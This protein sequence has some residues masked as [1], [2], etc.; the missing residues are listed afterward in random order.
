MLVSLPLISTHNTTKD[1]FMNKIH[2]LLELQPNTHVIT[3]T[4]HEEPNYIYQIIFVDKLNKSTI[5]Q[6]NIEF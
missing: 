3:E 5:L 6:R 4:I 2:E 1:N